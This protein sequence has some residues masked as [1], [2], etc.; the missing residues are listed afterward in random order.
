MPRRPTPEER[1][2]YAS[3]IGQE[4]LRFG[5]VSCA[6]TAGPDAAGYPFLPNMAPRPYLGVSPRWRTLNWPSRACQSM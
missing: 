3:G 5:D 4:C 1:Q 2:A 6:R